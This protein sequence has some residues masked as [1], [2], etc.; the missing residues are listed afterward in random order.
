MNKK[1][2]IRALETIAQYDINSKYGE[3]I[4]PYGCD[5]PYIAKNALAEYK[6]VPQQ[7]EEEERCWPY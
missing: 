6:A 1:I 7:T 5:A 2:L 4:C 3:N